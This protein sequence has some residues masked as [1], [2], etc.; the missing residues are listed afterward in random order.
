MPFGWPAPRAHYR[1]PMQYPV[2]FD[3]KQTAQVRVAVCKGEQLT[4]H[5]RFQ[6]ATWMKASLLILIFLASAAPAS[7]EE[8]QISCETVRTY[9]A[10]VGV[11]QAKAQA[12][13]AG[14]TAQQERRARRCFVKTKEIATK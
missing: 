9:V 7:A 10:Q 13:A 8:L 5:V 12:R 6:K 4:W 11:V 2:G 14:M 1:A 3:L